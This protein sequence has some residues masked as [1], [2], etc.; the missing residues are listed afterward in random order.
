MINLSIISFEH[1]HAPHYLECLREMPGVRIVAL[2]EPDGTRLEPYAR[3]LA[4]VPIY[5]DYRRMLQE[6]SLHGVIIC[7]SNA[8]H[9]AA[10]IDCAR[11]GIPVLCEKPLAAKTADARE[12]LA[13]CQAHDVL[14][15]MCFPARFS[16]ALDQAKQLIH[17][18]EL[19]KTLACLRWR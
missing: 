16:P 12:M 11:A 4:G 14:L 17:K 6:V 13:V 19:G 7:S 18:G 2:A 1:V 15:G 3:L 8:K 9:K 10:V 5:G